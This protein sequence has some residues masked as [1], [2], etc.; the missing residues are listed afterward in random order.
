MA[1]GG[2][3][4]GAPDGIEYELID[5]VYQA[6]R[7]PQAWRA[8]LTQLQRLL[9]AEAV[10]LGTHDFARG[11]GS[12]VMDVGL[13]P[14]LAQRYD[15]EFSPQNPWMRDEHAY[16]IHQVTAGEDVLLNA[17]LMKTEFY[18]RYLRPQ[19][20]LHRLCGVADRSGSES[21][22][23][24]AY[25]RP[26]QPGFGVADKVLLARFLPHA[27]R[28]LELGWELHR[29][30]ST[31]H[32]LLDV[33]DQLPTAVV[34]VDASGQPLEVNSAA[35]AI[36]AMN[37]G[38]SVDGR[39]LNPLWP[40]EREQLQRLIAGACGVS[41][42]EQRPPGGHLTVRRPS[43][44]RPFLLVVSPLPRAVADARGR[45]RSVAVVVIKDS[46]TEAQASASSLEEVAELY[47]LTP[48]ETRLVALIMDSL[49]LF[50]AAE[51]L[52]ITRNTA[53]THM[54]HIY[55]KTGTR[56]QAELVR[57]LGQLV[58]DTH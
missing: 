8:V 15:L 9:A 37:D 32:V 26:D 42:G 23:I 36:L 57:R 19:R 39:R 50:E 41:N 6:V 21:W 47:E 20:V 43:G 5:L 58:T 17:D 53:R 12:R 49:G 33:L 18:Q 48:A 31:R 13:D 14:G 45:R 16:R 10:L 28:A 1:T 34:V 40:A 52:G 56:R 35:E 46:Q 55:A 25:R 44:F 3:G 27:Q 24:G 7:D 2:P 51:R 11:A 54:K 30:Q 4:A 29:V 22:C 38:L